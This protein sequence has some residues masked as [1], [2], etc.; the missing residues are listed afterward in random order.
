LIDRVTGINGDVTI[1]S[2]SLNNYMKYYI[3]I[4]CTFI[5]IISLSAVGIVLTSYIGIVAFLIL[6]FP[7]VYI[8]NVLWDVFFKPEGRDS[9]S[10][11]ELGLERAIAR[12]TPN[13]VTHRNIV[14]SIG[15]LPNGGQNQPNNIQI[16]N[17]W[18]RLHWPRRGLGTGTSVDDP[19][20]YSVARSMKVA[21]RPTSH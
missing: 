10:T 2:H 21:T 5:A 16:N 19:G 6:L 15:H 3:G 20:R 1:Y 4:I 8:S 9:G 11:N 13:R 14:R 18:A 12:D 7:I 17:V